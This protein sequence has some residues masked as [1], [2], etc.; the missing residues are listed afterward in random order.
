[1][2]TAG[3]WTEATARMGAD[4]TR[5]VL[6][7]AAFNSTTSPEFTISVTKDIEDVETV[8]RML[9]KSGIESPGLSYDFVRLW[10]AD[11][12]ISRDDQRFVIASLFGEPVVLLP[13]H[14]RRICG[15]TV[16][17]WFP[18]SQVGCYAPIARHAALAAMGSPGR[19]KLWHDIFAALKDADALYLRS[20]ATEVDGRSELFDELGTTLP[21]EPLYRAEFSSW[22]ECDRLQRSRSRR[23]HDRQ[24]G[25]RLAA[26]GN[27]DFEI[28]A[29]PVAGSEAIEVMFRQRSARF[30]A[31]GIR[32]VF[33]CD[34]LLSFYRRALQPESGLDVRLHVLRLDGE[35]VAVRYNIVH[36][37]RMFC[38]IS[39]MSDDREVQFGS[40]GKQCLLRTVQSLFQDN[41]T[42]F[43][44]GQ[45][46]TDE[47]RHWC[48]IEMPLRHHYIALSWHGQ[49][50][51]GLHKMLQRLRADVKAKP[52]LK[53]SLRQ[54][55]YLATCAVSVFS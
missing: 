19:R 8:W 52:T 47:K 1:M 28:I 23:K 10:I 2:A 7:Q 17:T 39:S 9:T 6:P 55:R 49:V 15:V 35:I 11:R 54:V 45:G 16:Y 51:V 31:Q 41:F 44:M 12:G 29:D 18:S 37:N 3:A 13:L 27:V 46:F 34:A 38:L 42:M 43:D 40:P 36:G 53:N 32:D 50:A 25:D 20:V 24:Q 14:R 48:N 21:A 4:T 5:I 22:E 26:L 30:R 33:V